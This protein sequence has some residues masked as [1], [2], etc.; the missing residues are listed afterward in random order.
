MS[1]YADYQYKVFFIPKIS[2]QSRRK[3]ISNPYSNL[4][5]FSHN[6]SKVKPMNLRE[7]ARDRNCVGY[8]PKPCGKGE[9]VL[10]HGDFQM[11]PFKTVEHHNK[12]GTITY[13]HRYRFDIMK[14]SE[15]KASLKNSVREQLATFHFPTPKRL[16]LKKLF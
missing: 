14:A 9:D 5:K 2:I 16:N 15:R 6:I 7:Y 10:F 8:L 3:I 12:D 11:S 13:T 4:S 1:F